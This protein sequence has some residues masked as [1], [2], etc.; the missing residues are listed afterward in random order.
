MGELELFVCIFKRKV[1]FF[2]FVALGVRVVLMFEGLRY[3]T[4]MAFLPIFAYL[5]GTSCFFFGHMNGYVTNE[6][7]SVIRVLDIV[8]Y[9]YPLLIFLRICLEWKKGFPYP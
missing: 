3:P 1:I 5:L 9:N 4:F 2:E 8:I 7:K 6:G